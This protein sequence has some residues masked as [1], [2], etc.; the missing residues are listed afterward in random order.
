MTDAPSDD[1]A[2]AAYQ[3]RP[4]AFSDVAARAFVGDAAR[5][6]PC[7]TFA[8]AVEAR[9]VDQMAGARAETME[10]LRAR[11]FLI[12]VRDRAVWLA[13]PYL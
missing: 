4:G 1:V 8:A 9:I 12:R 6:L 2:E 13:S 11:P 5:L 3:G 10:T 7:P